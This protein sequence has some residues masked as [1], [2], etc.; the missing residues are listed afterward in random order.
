MQCHESPYARNKS[1]SKHLTAGRIS[2]RSIDKLSILTDKEIPLYQFIIVVKISTMVWN[3]QAA[4]LHKKATRQ[5][6]F[7]QK[8]DTGDI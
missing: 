2:R 5:K 6:L 3:M 1:W 4:C 8:Y 7:E